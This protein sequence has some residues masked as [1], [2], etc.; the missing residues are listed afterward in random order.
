MWRKPNE[1]KPSSQPMP[2]PAAA[3]IR[4]EEPPKSVIDAPVSP[5]PSQSAPVPSGQTPSVAPQVRPVP[6]TASRISSGLKINGELSGDADL[7]VDGEVK[8]KIRLNGATL[9]IG[10][11][12]RV[13]AELEARSISV[14]GSV[15]GNLKAAESVH[16]GSASNTIGAIT[17][18]RLGIDDGARLRGKVETIRANQSAKSSARPSESDEAHAETV[19][20]QSE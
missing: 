5:A 19:G 10:P 15:Q 11:S 7:Y 2:T 1:A 17:T 6:S 12:G 8:G 14:E 9:T 13:Q 18:P 4:A 20:A 3:P 16:L